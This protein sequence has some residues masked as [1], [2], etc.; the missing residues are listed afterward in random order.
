MPPSSKS[1]LLAAGLI[2]A[3]LGLAACQTAGKV[4]VMQSNAAAIAPGSTYAWA[5]MNQALIAAAEPGLAN[6]I[7]EA[8]LRTAVETTLAARGFRKVESRADAQLIATYRVVLQGRTDARVTQTAG[9]TACGFRGCLTAGRQ[10]FD[11]RQVDY[12]QGTLVL[13]LADAR[14]GALVWRAASEKRV[15]QKDAEPQRLQATLMAM[16]RSLPSL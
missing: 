9:R 1:L 5:P 10:D 8:R 15:D 6:P 4:S 2:A 14:T 13:D 7:A 16:T 3:T 11:V 12:T